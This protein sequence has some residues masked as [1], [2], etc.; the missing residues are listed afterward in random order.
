M[1]VDILYDCAQGIPVEKAD[2]EPGRIGGKAEDIKGAVGIK[3][4]L[5]AGKSVSQT[6][7]GGAQCVIGQALGRRCAEQQSAG[8]FPVIRVCTLCPA[9]HGGV[10]DALHVVPVGQ[11]IIQRGGIGKGG[12]FADRRVQALFFAVGA[13]GG[14][15]ERD[16]GGTT[17][18]GAGY[19]HDGRV[20]CFRHVR[21]AGHQT[22]GLYTIALVIVC[23]PCRANGRILL[24]KLSIHPENQICAF[25]QVV[26]TSRKGGMLGGLLRLPGVKKG[27]D[28]F[29]RHRI[30]FVQK[31]VVQFGTGAETFQTSFRLSFAVNAQKVTG[32]VP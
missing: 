23:L 31:L 25:H 1:G 11:Q 8:I 28:C 12:V 19:A 10:S 22:L 21:L 24:R 18:L 20:N 4:Q 16:Y 2:G 14:S 29:C 30:H 7:Y 17:G 26:P 15:V 9:D 27:Q 3:P 32:I 6:L 13:K 5:L